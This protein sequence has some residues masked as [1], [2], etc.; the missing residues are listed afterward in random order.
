MLLDAGEEDS[1]KAFRARSNSLAF[2]CALFA[3]AVPLVEGMQKYFKNH[4]SFRK[5]ANVIHSDEA[6]ELRD[7]S[8]SRLRNKLV[9]HFDASEVAEQLKTL[10]REDPVFVS[11][12]GHTKVNT[13]IQFADIVAL[14]TFFG[15]DFPNDLK[16][17]R[18]KL[19]KIRNITL[20]FVTAAEDFLVAIMTERGWIEGQ[21]E[22]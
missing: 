12:I 19:H 9:F 13:Y 2:T 18:E 11:G 1:P 10:D 14:R 4:P 16:D 20:S 17:T 3:E 6:K 22:E 7:G 15:P 5:V 21:I 8:L